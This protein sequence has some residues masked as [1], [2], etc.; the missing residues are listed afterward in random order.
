MSPWHGGAVKAARCWLP[1]HHHLLG[2]SSFSSCS[3]KPRAQL[4]L[5]G[6]GQSRLRAQA[7]EDGKEQRAP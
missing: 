1:H 2:F 5:L 3:Y 6:G 4:P 7:S